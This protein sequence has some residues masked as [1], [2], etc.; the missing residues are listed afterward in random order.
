MERS[1]RVCRI[2]QLRGFQNSECGRFSLP[3]LLSISHVKFNTASFLIILMIG[4]LSIIVDRAIDF[5][6][7]RDLPISHFLIRQLGRRI[8]YTRIRIMI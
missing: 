3:L 8:R 5:K 2:Y 7:L 6:Y 1:R 4:L